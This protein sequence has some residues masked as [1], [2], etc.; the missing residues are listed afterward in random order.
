MTCQFVEHSFAGHRAQLFTHRVTVGVLYLSVK[1]ARRFEH[2]YIGKV[3]DRQVCLLRDSF[4]TVQRGKRD[5]YT[6]AMDFA[7][8]LHLL[9]NQSINQSNQSDYLANKKNNA[10]YGEN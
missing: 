8:C 9:I 2:V 7:T 1:S 3:V 6:F 5:A 4:E 10:W